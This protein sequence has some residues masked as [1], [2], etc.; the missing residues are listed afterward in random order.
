MATQIMLWSLAV[1]GVCIAAGF[2]A[3]LIHGV[4]DMFRK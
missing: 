4:V 3:L 2:V 1:C